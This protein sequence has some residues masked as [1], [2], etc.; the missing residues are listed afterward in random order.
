MNDYDVS[1]FMSRRK[2]RVCIASTEMDFELYIAQMMLFR[3]LIYTVHP[4]TLMF[5]F[6][7]IA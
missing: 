3:R 7:G 1:E 6:L 4:C 5:R 2:R